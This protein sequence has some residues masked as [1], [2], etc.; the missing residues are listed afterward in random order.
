MITVIL[1]A[2]GNGTRAHLPVNKVLTEYNSIPLLCYSLSAF[3]DVADEILVACR[4]EDEEK[5]LRLTA[6]YP[7][8]KTV[9]GGETRSLSVYYALVQAK[10]DYVLIHDAAR[11]FVSEKIISDCLASVKEY[12]SGVCAIPATDTVAIAE[13]ECI[14]AVPDRSSVRLVQTP[15]GFVREKL[16]SA[17]EKAIASDREFTDESGLYAAYCEPPH[18][19]KGDRRNRKL[20]YSEDFL[21]AE[22][23]G[24]GTDTHAFGK[25]Q[26][27]IV[28]AGIRIPHSQGLIAH[29]DGDVL[30]H[31]VMD[32]LLSAAGLRDIGYYF[33]D[34]D[35][36]YRN[37]DSMEL[38]GTVMNLIADCGLR[39]KNV[40]ISVLAETPRL[41]G[42][43]GKM[44]TNLGQKRFRCLATPSESPQARTKNSAT[45]ARARALPYL[46]RRF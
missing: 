5:I 43:I 30:V 15:Q 3:A 27:Y 34:T 24:F 29:S 13:R 10:G 46:A 40:S 28:L 32:A 44:K 1:C 4:K 9:L 17:F 11:P 20:T 37:A 7:Q 2:A 41:A 31:A 25:K 6:P 33:P 22:R 26:N 14:A 35:E 19:C 21:P 12:G 16:L 45:S 36:K 8:A 23:V 39:P 18:L 42:Y 38:L